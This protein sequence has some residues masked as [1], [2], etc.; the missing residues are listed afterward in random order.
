MWSAPR[1]RPLPRNG[2]HTATTQPP[3]QKK[4]MDWP[5]SPNGCISQNCRTLLHTHTTTCMCGALCG[6]HVRTPGSIHRHTR[7]AF[8]APPA[9]PADPLMGGSVQ[10]SPVQVW[11]PQHPRRE[12]AMKRSPST[13]VPAPAQS[14]QQVSGAGTGVQSDVNNTAGAAPGHRRSRK[15]AS[16]SR[17]P[18][19]TSGLGGGGEG[20]ALVT[21]KNR[22]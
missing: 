3:P 16:P 9:R 6:E 2:R 20:V 17:S 22:S 10:F 15:A 19:L 8:V 1:R 7:S 5:L 14:M 21:P 11:T 12:Q 13:E 4:W 18:L